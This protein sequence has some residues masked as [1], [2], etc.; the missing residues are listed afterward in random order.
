MIVRAAAQLLDARYAALGMPDDA[1]LV[2]RVRRRGRQRRGV[3][4]DRP[5]ATPAR[6][7][8]GDAARGQGP[9]A[10]RRAQGGG[11][12]GLAVGPS[13]P[14]RLPRRADPRRLRRHSASSSWPTSGPRWLHR[15]RRGALMLFAAHAAIALTNA[16]LYERNRE[17]TVIEERARLA[18]ELHDAVAQKLF[19]LRLTA[20]RR[21]GRRDPTRRPSSNACRRSPRRPSPSCVR[22]SSSCAPPN[23]PATAWPSR[24]ASTCRC[25]TVSGERAAVR[26]CGSRAR[27]CRCRRRPRPWCSASPRR[28]STTRCGTDGR[29]GVGAPAAGGR[30]WRSATTASASTPPDRAHATGWAW[31]P[32]ASARPRSA[33]C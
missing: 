10:R 15:R 32:C 28:R 14:P 12:R 6:A 21:A 25:S 2:R 24:C 8:R 30:R 9:A 31:R 33:A 1:G 5:A 29:R 16:R 20:G 26:P 7:A 22:R 11:V 27:T 19:S 17:L 23:S 13:R 4:G 18:R 3:G